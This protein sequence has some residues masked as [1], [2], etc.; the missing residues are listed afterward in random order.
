MDSMENF[1]SNQENS[2]QESSEEFDEKYENNQEESSENFDSQKEEM[3]REESSSSQNSL[4]QRIS[5]LFR[6]RNIESEELQ[7]SL[8]NDGNIITS[9]S[10]RFL[11]KRN[12]PYCFGFVS[13]RIYRIKSRTNVGVRVSN[14]PFGL[15]SLKSY[16]CPN[17]QA[18]L[19]TD[20]FYNKSSSIALVGGRESGKSSFITVFCE[21]LL[22]RPSILSNLGIFGSITNDEGKDLFDRNQWMLVEQNIAL[23]LTSDLESPIVIRLQSK[24]HN[25]V[26]YLTLIDSPGEHFEQLNTLLDKHPNL[27][28][29]DGMIFLMNPLDIKGISNLIKE[30]LPK[31]V[32]NRY[33]K[34]R[35]KNFDIIE[36]LYQFYLKTGKIRPNV[37]IKIPTAFCLSRADLLNEVSNLYIPYDFDPDLLEM[38]EIIDEMHLVFDEIKDLFE[39]SDQRLINL[40]DKYFSNYSLFPVSPLGKIPSNSAGRQ[41]ISGGIEPRGILQPFLWILKETK[42][43]Q[44]P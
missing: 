11:F 34:N 23:D 8:K 37:R 29:A 31:A 28:Y 24:H 3:P 25:N 39:E 15:P 5:N 26:V 22:N 35:I 12:C 19:P 9:F 38:E 17:C 44:I 16:E 10:D 18:E 14:I 32:P 41:I 36:N 33:Q 21:L 42:F 4:F 20:F 30:V 40:M 2:S 1:N 43:I 6:K 13:K 27:Q 7:D